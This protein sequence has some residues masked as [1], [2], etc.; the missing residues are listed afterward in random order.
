VPINTLKWQDQ[1][2]TLGFEGDWLE[3][4]PLIKAD[5]QDEAGKLQY[6][7]IDLALV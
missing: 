1:K 6:L 3:H 4:H 2:L 7:D 5:L